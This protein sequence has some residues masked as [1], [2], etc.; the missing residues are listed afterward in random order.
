MGSGDR[1]QGT[2]ISHQAWEMEGSELQ[3]QGASG[4]GE[5][6]RCRFSVTSFAFSVTG[7]LTGG[8]F[9]EAQSPKCPA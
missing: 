2:Q 8:Q 5:Y 7:S 4:L 6:S 9:Q 3:T 1:D